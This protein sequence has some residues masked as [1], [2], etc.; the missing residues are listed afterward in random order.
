MKLLLIRLLL[1]FLFLLPFVAAAETIA[2]VVNANNGV[3]ALS[4][5]E[6]I[7][8]FLGRFRQFP[9][10]VAAQ[11]ID[12]PDTHPARAAF[13][14]RLVNKNPAEINAYWAR[15]IFSGRTS[16][17]LTTVRFDDVFN[18]VQSTPGGI[19]YMERSKVGGRLKIVFELP[20]QGP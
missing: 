4:R 11:P 2:V 3:E 16:P 13:Y 17:P 14:R 15:L 9:S 18:L 12:L 5:D 20:E 1:V 10:G 7:N 8:I 19:S 6:V